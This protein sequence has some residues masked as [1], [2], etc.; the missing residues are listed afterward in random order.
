MNEADDRG[1]LGVATQ[2]HRPCCVMWH[3][4]EEAGR[5][6]GQKRQEGE[7]DEDRSPPRVN[8]EKRETEGAI[9]KSPTRQTWYLC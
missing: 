2:E 9:K 8:T 4:A 5:L 6:H 3:C 1:S 7:L